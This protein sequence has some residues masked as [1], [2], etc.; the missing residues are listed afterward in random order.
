[1]WHIE[2][3]VLIVGFKAKILFLYYEDLERMLLDHYSRG[4]RFKLLRNYFNC[5]FLFN[6]INLIMFE[7]YFLAVEHIA[8]CILIFRCIFLVYIGLLRLSELLLIQRLTL[9]QTLIM[10]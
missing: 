1:M 3:K 4:L 10:Q 7:Y 8:Y 9:I 6:Q 5:I 2:N